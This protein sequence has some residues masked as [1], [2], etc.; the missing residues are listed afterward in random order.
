MVKKFR[1]G[2]SVLVVAGSSKGKV[3]KILSV[4]GDKKV[5]VE[6]VNLAFIHNKP[7]AQNPGVISRKEKSI[8]VSNI[9]HVENGAPI[10][11]GFVTEVGEGKAFTR[12]SRVLKNG[13]K[14]V[15]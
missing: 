14:L 11:V 2:D 5:V 13:K 15:K 3:G 12:K 10:K 7:T 9:S 4:I 6:G 8:H 1:S